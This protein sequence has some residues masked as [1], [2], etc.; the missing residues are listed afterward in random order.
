[1]LFALQTLINSED[2]LIPRVTEFLTES[3]QE[4]HVE[5][6]TPFDEVTS[7]TWTKMGELK[8]AIAEHARS[9][10]LSPL[11]YQC[12]LS[13]FTD[14]KEDG[15]HLLADILSLVEG[16][17]FE[18]T[19][20]VEILLSFLVSESGRNRQMV[21]GCFRQLATECS[22]ESV[23][24]IAEAVDPSIKDDPLEVEDDEN[25]ESDGDDRDDEQDDESES[26]D[27]EQEDEDEEEDDEDE[28]ESED[29][30]EDVELLKARLKQA[31]GDAAIGS[32]DEE[33]D[34]DDDMTDEQM[35][36][37]DEAIGGAFKSMV[38][39]IKHSSILRQLTRPLR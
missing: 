23:K 6:I 5:L 38:R 20:I 35:M 30:T 12:A 26:E 8:S 15:T 39:L 11:V 17:S 10:I 27:D 14:R 34:D 22:D 18:D 2:Q 13:I 3:M 19:A 24:L 37:I 33:D 28:A 25:D 31:M 4:K 21:I 9:K 1:M 32:D 16:D 29:E 7:D 36:N